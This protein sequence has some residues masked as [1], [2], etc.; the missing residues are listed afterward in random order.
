MNQTAEDIS[1]RATGHK[2][3]L[4]NPVCIYAYVRVTK[5]L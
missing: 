5:N 2:A 4:S 1:H 3:N